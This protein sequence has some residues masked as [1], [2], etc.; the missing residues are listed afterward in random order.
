MYINYIL[1]IC[2]MTDY[3]LY[4]EYYMCIFNIDPELLT[5]I[6]TKFKNITDNKTQILNNKIQ[7]DNKID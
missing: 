3:D 6:V 1:Y 2:I 4:Q 5:K 7:I